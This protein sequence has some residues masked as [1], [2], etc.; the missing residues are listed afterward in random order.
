MNTELNPMDKFNFLIGTWVLEYKVP[1][2][3]F[4]IE[5]TGKGEGSFRRIL[6]DQ[7]V[8]FDYYAKLSKS[9]RAA[10]AIFAW[11]D[12]NKIYRYWWF[13]DSGMFMKA[14]CYFTDDNTILLNWHN[15]LLIQTFKR[16]ED[17]KKIELQMKYPINK[18]D[19]EIVLEVLFTKKK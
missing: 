4:S 12:K 3:R 5:D 11:D 14:D 15:S 19:Y 13:E 2:S 17:G 18:N 16:I 10:H 1:K 9:E 7:Y 6:N 8:A